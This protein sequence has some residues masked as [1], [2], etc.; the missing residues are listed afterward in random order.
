MKS[1]TAVL[2]IV[3][4]CSSLT[5]AE[6]G[7]R[8]GTVG[9]AVEHPW[10]RL[11]VRLGGFAV[12][13]DT[14]AQVDS[15]TLGEGTGFNLESDTGLDKE[16]TEG[17]LDGHVRLGRR[18]RIDYGALL[19]RRNAFRQIDE[20]IQFGDELFDVDAEVRTR[21]RNDI[22]KLA[23]RYDV[24]RRPR[25]DLGLSF[26]VSAFA[27]DMEL[28]AMQAGGGMFSGE[29]ED[30]IAP[31]P[32]LGL[33]TDVRLADDWYFRAG[34][35]FFDVDID[36]REGD[37]TEL[38]AA[39]DWYPFRHWGFG[40]GFNRVELNYLDT[41]LPEVDFSYMYSGAMVYVSYV[42]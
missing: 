28:E 12:R 13:F 35:E 25:W 9:S 16:R 36:D 22:F 20:Q 40:A 19:L 1:K 23:Y 18:H 33:H 7:D 30:F 26:G 38:R 21:F 37:L 6:D 4:A 14:S 41:R 39:V 15:E 32:T 31:I 5:Y 2:L 17:R 42:R 11:S 27:V 3:L 34:G 24:V 10:N 8:N 29:T